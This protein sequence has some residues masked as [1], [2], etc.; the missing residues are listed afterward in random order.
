MTSIRN[1]I[2][3]AGLFVSL[4]LHAQ[5]AMVGSFNRIGTPIQTAPPDSIVAVTAESQGLSLVAPE[6]LPFGGTFWEVMPSGIMAPLPCPPIDQTLPIY[7]ITDTAFLVDATGGQV[8]VNTRQLKTMSLTQAATSDVV[9][10][11]LD[12]QATAIVN[13]INQVQTASANQQVRTMAMAMGVPTPGGDGGTNSYTPNGASFTI[14][15]YGTN[16]WI[17]QWNMASGSV[18]GIAFNTLADVS[19]DL[20]TNVDLTTTNWGSTGLFIVGSEATNWTPLP[21][22]AVSLTNNCFFRLRSWIDSDNVGIPDWWQVQYFGS[23]GINPYALSSSGDGFTIWQKYQNGLDPNAFETPPAPNNFAAVLSTNGTDVLLSWDTAQGSVTNYSLMRASYN[24]T[25][26]DYDYTTI[27]TLGAGVDS[28]VDAGAVQTSD[29]LNNNFYEVTANYADNNTSDM[30]YSPIY[31]TAPPTTSSTSAQPYDIHVTASLVRNNTGRWQVMFSSLP[32]NATSLQFIWTDGNGNATTQSLS[33]NVLVNGVYQIPD[34]DVM[35]VLGDSLAVRGIGANGEQGQLAQVGNLPDDAPYF[36]DGRQHMKQNLN[37]LIRGASSYQPFFSLMNQDF[38][39]GNFGVYYDSLAS[40]FNETATSFEEFSFLHHNLWQFSDIIPL[41]VTLDNLWPFTANYDL[42]NYFVDAARTNLV[43]FGSTNFNFQPNFA[44]NIPAPLMLTHSDPYWILQAGFS[45]Y[46]YYYT[47]TNWAV[48]VNGTQTEASLAGSKQNL[49]NLPYQ[50]GCEV[51]MQWS[52][53]NFSVNC[54]YQ[55]LTPGSSVTTSS[56]Y[57]VGDYA[58]WCSAPTLSFNSYYFAPLINPNASTMSLPPLNQQPFPLPIDDDFNVTNQSA[59]LIIAGVGQPMIVGGWAKYG[60]QG[61]SP[62]KF[63]YLGQY[64]ETNAFLLDDSGNPTTNRAGILSPYGE[65]FPTQAGKARLVTLPDIDPPYQQGTCTVSV[66]SLNVDANHDGTMD[67]SYFGQD[68]TSASK[69]YVFWCNNNFDRVHAVDGS[70]TE[71][72]DLESANCPFTPY[73]TT[74]DCN[75]VD[76]SGS[77][78]IPCARD[79][80]DFSRLWITGVTSN[81]LASLP[82]GNTVTLNWGDVGNPNP[83]NPTIDLFQ[84]ADTDGG[85]GY[86]TNSAIALQQ[87]NNNQCWYLNRLA[88]GG[89]IQLTGYQFNNFWAGNQFIWCGV[90]NGSGKLSLT[91]QDGNGNVLGQASVYIQIKDIKQMYERWTVGDIGNNPPMNTAINAQ[92]DGLGSYETAF[93][94][95]PATTNTP[96]ILFVHGWNMQIWEKDRFAETSFKRLF[97]QGYQGRFGEFRWPTFAGFP[98]AE[99]SQQAFDLRNF[100]NSESNAWASAAGLLNKLNDL[101]S[102]YPGNVY[103]MA[104]SM[105]NVVAGE[106]LRLAGNSQV[107]NTYIAMQGALS[108]HAYDPNTAA[109]S[110]SF[111]TP[112]DYA[113]YRTSGA[114]YFNGSAGAGTYVNFFNTND[115]ALHSGTFSWE[116]DQN[117]KPDNSITGYPGYHYNVSS[118]HANGFYVQFGS[119]TNDFRNLNFPGDTYAIFPYCD[120]ARSYALGAQAGVAGVFT[121]SKEINLNQSPYSFN[122]THKFHSGEFRSDNTQRWQFWNAVLVQMGLN[123]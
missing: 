34:A 25:T 101:N 11:A 94:Y 59:P 42:A 9:A 114:P 5:T 76:A 41:D 8:T 30:T 75:F 15:D 44:V 103:L 23:V 3:A 107:V 57:Y 88:P 60:I 14:P 28:F 105:G 66:V 19:Y 53:G 36:V 80:E 56:G 115:Y 100:D 74:P 38:A 65:F 37:F 84:A 91:F 32:A 70:D 68:Q 118:L 72:D 122:Q 111:S 90:T 2:I 110:Y 63:A 27:S 121:T 67:L 4:N 51:D 55:I 58:S 102:T 54:L 31:T 73:T 48:T 22:M 29:D 85:I 82:A 112:D 89:S 99:F 113:S 62:A 116:Y 47:A 78:Q 108:A 21:L 96:Y 50:T 45:P 33:A 87:T 7:A 13:L 6:D 109:R 46:Y 64:F 69:P 104:H 18:T 83:N 43:P 40:R 10:S 95:A 71:Q 119:G 26:Y 106:A 92:E 52:H 12:T 123:N 98:V 35:N 79:L 77:R 81:L 93:H 16:L 1:I 24:P 39:F 61:S 20:L 17:A 120:Q 86:L 97:W 117:H 49:F